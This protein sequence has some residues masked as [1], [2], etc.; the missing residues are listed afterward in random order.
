MHDHSFNVQVTPT[1]TYQNWHH[2]NFGGTCMSAYIH[3]DSFTICYYMIYSCLVD[4]KY[5]TKINI[6]TNSYGRRQHI[7]FPLGVL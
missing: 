1:A 4:L 3:E 7:F 2:F 6:T 5:T